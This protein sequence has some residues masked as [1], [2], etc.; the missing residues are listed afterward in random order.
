MMIDAMWSVQ[1]EKSYFPV[2]RLAHGIKEEWEVPDDAARSGKE[3]VRQE[4]VR[5]R[6]CSISCCSCSA[7]IPVYQIVAIWGV[8]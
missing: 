8:G 4:G 7:A 6:A 3:E 1:L 2:V 5:R